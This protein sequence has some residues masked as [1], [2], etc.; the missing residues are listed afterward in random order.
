MLSKGDS[1]ILDSAVK[2]C[3]GQTLKLTLIHEENSFILLG[4]SL[5]HL[6]LNLSQIYFQKADS[7]KL[8]SC[9]FNTF[10]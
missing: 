8:F 7:F 2:A 9:N 10:Q 3:H 6:P 4:P 1:N 5:L